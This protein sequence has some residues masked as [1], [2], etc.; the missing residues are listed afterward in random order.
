MKDFNRDNIRTLAVNGHIV[1][2]YAFDSENHSGIL[3]IKVKRDAEE[4]RQINEDY[5][6]K[7]IGLKHNIEFKML[8]YLNV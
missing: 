3:W 5:A 2:Q 4:R 6:A 1:A 7:L 8:A